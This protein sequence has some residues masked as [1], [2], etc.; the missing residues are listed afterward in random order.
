MYLPAKMRGENAAVEIVAIGGQESGYRARVQMGGGPAHSFWQM[1]MGGGVHG[2]MR[3]PATSDL[4]QKACSD[5]NVAFTEPAVWQAMASNDILGAIFARLL[6]WTSPAPMPSIDDADG[7]Y[8]Y[9]EGIW[10]PG[11]PDSSRWPAAY[12]AALN[13]L[14]GG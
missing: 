1:E 11:K 9:Y 5:Q 12:S 8:A 6:L 2:V 13:A 4:A 3:H 7:L 14:R 10:R